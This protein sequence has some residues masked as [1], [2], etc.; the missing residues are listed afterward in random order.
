MSNKKQRINIV[1]G[2]F[3]PFTVGHKSLILNLYKENGLPCC[4][5]YIDNK[6]T[7]VRHPFSNDLVERCI[8]A[9]FTEQEK[10]KYLADTPYMKVKNA[11][12]VEIGQM[13]YDNNLEPVL[14]AC[15]TDRYNSYKKMA[16]NPKYRDM[17]KLPDDFD[18]IV[19][20]RDENLVSGTLT[21]KAI[22]DDDIESINKMTEYHKNLTKQSFNILIGELK[23]RI[24]MVSEK[25]VN[26]NE[27][28]YIYENKGEYILNYNNVQTILANLLRKFG[29]ENNLKSGLSDN[30]FLQKSVH[31]K[32]IFEVKFPSVEDD[33]ENKR[34]LDDI[35]GYINNDY[36]DWDIEILDDY[37][38]SIWGRPDTSSTKFSYRIQV[39]I[40]DNTEPYIYFII[41]RNEAK[42]L[43]SS[44]QL[45]P[46]KILSGEKIDSEHGAAQLFT[47]SSDY[48]NNVLDNINKNL[49]DDKYSSIRTVI[50]G[51]VKAIQDKRNYK[52][53][54]SFTDTNINAWLNNNKQGF[55]DID[56]NIPELQ[57]VSKF[58]IACIEKDFGEILGPCVLYTLFHDIN[59]SFPLTET[60]SLVDYF[61]NGFGVSAKQWGGGGTPSGSAIFNSIKDDQIKDIDELKIDINSIDPKDRKYYYNKKEIDFIKKVGST[62]KLSTKQQQIQ[63]INEFVIKL[64]PDLFTETQKELFLKLKP[65]K[66]ESTANID[67]L[68]GDDV[69]RFFTDLYRK[70][71]YR[72]TQSTS[73][74]INSLTNDFWYNSTDKGD[75]LLKCS[76]LLYPLYKIAIDNINKTYGSK[77]IDDDAITT[78]IN[79]QINIKQIYFGINKRKLKLK[80]CSSEAERWYCKMSGISVNNMFNNKL[81]VKIR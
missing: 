9:S 65:D 68:V 46:N 36:P 11:N 78:V 69:Q 31:K 29:E 32:T 53:T 3:Q 67:T 56:I 72:D 54:G 28:I 44:K 58:D 81:G 16:D 43:L 27:Y 12:I 6:K 40:P 18:V 10:S 30:N 73:Y 70:L 64:I 63:L 21:R 62:Y 5:C 74:K 66:K 39:S 22:K 59:V 26:L 61:V 1:I 33:D 80:V 37:T 17:G 20:D 79:K 41:N 75:N 45:T 51:I 47:N 24:N 34:F 57:N 55:I 42:G 4:I 25:L 2:R 48:Y 35:V 13:L 23:E 19:L 49:N 52:I 50:T 7:D 76:I 8:D 77:N 71:N 14:L 38:S 60:E 15:G